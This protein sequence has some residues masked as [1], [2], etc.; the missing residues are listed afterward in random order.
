M[1]WPIFSTLSSSSSA[2]SRGIACSSGSWAMSPAPAKSRPSPARCAERDVA[3]AVRLKG[4]RHAAKPRGHGV[5]VRRLGVEGDEAL[6]R[7]G[8]DPVF[9]RL[10]VGDLGIAGVVE[11]DGLQPLLHAAQLRRWTV[12]RARLSPHAARHRRR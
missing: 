10:Q 1:F 9:K 12:Q 7:R 6:L 3:G 8:R 5:E 11:G 2:F 4:Q